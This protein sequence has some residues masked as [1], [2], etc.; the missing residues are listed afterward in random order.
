MIAVHNFHNAIEVVLR[1]ILLEYEIRGAKQLN[2]DF[3]TMLKDID[4]HEAFQEQGIKLPYRQQLRNLNQTRNLVQHHGVEPPSATM[5]EWRVFT[6]RALEDIC[7]KYFD[8]K[9]QDLNPTD[10]I[11]DSNLRK[12]LGIAFSALEANQLTEALIIAAIAY[13]WAEKSVLGVIGEP[14]LF[15]I[16]DF[17]PRR[18]LWEDQKTDDSRWRALD[19]SLEAINNKLEEVS[20][21]CGL[22]SSGLNLADVRR[23]RSNLPR[24]HFAVSGKPNVQIADRPLHGEDIK[25]VLD[26]ILNAIIDWQNLG[27]KPELPHQ[28]I[29]SATKIIDKT[30]DSF[31]VVRIKVRTDNGGS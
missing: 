26:F 7:D 9:Y 30:E 4:N 25:W 8:I 28:G 20:A 12:I 14:A 2:I 13:K 21:L 29:E 6:H 17:G 1:A 24:V 10:M 15:A 19:R 23:L 27:L 11:D 5:D 22:A 31:S 3:D 16:P 18:E